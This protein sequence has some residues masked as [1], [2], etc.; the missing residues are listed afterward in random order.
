MDGRAQLDQPIG[1]GRSVQIAAADREA[2]I[3]QDL[4]DAAHADAADGHQMDV[5]RITEQAVSPPP[6]RLM[7]DR[8]DGRQ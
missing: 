2:E 5:S 6:S 8:H 1:H 7:A 4:G 3:Q